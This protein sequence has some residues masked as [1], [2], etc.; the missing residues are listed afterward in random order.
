MTAFFNLS[1]LL[2]HINLFD[3][4]SSTLYI[5][6]WSYFV[7][8]SLFFKQANLVEEIKRTN[9]CLLLYYITYITLHFNFIRNNVRLSTPSRERKGYSKYSVN[10]I[11]D[12]KASVQASSFNTSTVTQERGKNETD[13]T[14]LLSFVLSVP[15]FHRS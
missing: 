1:Q 12:T 9:E 2:S 5:H 11:I 4:K 6:M 7:C 3:L 13:N 8:L 15:F 14:K 10:Y